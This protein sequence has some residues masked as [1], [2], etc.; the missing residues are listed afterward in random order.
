MNDKLHQEIISGFAVLKTEL[1][2]VNTRLDTLNNNVAQNKGKIRTLE[3]D[4]LVATSQQKLKMWL[5]N[6]ATGIVSAIL[7]A[8]V[9]WKLGLR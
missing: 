6:N 7:V 4:A 5:A 3:D 9:I 8:F 1:K 2:G